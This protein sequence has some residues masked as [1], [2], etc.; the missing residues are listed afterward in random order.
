MTG[1]QAPRTEPIFD[2]GLLSRCISCG[3]CLPACPTYA[4][5]G[6][7]A[8]SPRGRIS[9]MRALESGA[10]PPDD[11]TVTEQASFCLGCRACEPVCPAGVQYGEL[12]EQ[13]RGFQWTGSRRPAVVRL[14]ILAAERAWA[15]RIGGVLRRA[16]RT[17]AAARTAPAAAQH[18]LML[19]CFER[20]LFPGVSRSAL[21]LAPELAVPARQGCCGALHAHNGEPERGRQLAGSS[22]PGCRGRS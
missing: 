8:S 15:H 6:D 9:L 14:L 22:A 2:A 18:S 20:S 10:L 13:W 4:L 5:T 12:L 3:F 7:E 21:A 17:P 11:P 19:G 1:D 16:A